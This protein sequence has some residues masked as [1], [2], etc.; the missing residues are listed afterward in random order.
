M[1]LSVITIEMTKNLI[2]S[3]FLHPMKIQ[4]LKHYMATIFIDQML[5][6]ISIGLN[7]FADLILITSKQTSSFRNSL[8]HPLFEILYIYQ[9]SG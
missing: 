4:K 5:K 1:F 2:V 8:K 3:A 9:E 6:H 7:V